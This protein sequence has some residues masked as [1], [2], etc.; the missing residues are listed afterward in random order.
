[1][2]YE[3]LLHRLE[4]TDIFFIAPRLNKNTLKRNVSACDYSKLPSVAIA[5]SITRNWL[6]PSEINLRE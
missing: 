6:L 5:A 1:M 4:I 2:T 3:E